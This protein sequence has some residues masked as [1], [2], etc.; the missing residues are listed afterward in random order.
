[1]PDPSS[2]KRSLA[3]RRRLQTQDEIATVAIKLFT[4]VGFDETSMEDIADQAGVSRR[5]VYRHFATKADLVFE[6]PRRWLE[7]FEA[8]LHAAPDE[9]TTRERCER[10]II[11]IADMIAADPQPVLEAFAIRN[12]NPILGATH[13]S[14]DATWVELIFSSLVA[15]HGMEKAQPCMICAGALVGATNALIVGWSLAYPNADLVA[16]AQDAL[17]QCAGLWL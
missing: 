7:L 1:M 8:T 4:D 6:H 15:E 14:S 2:P 9:T 3:A 16:M 17:K 12:A 5:T 11:E 13:S 10:A